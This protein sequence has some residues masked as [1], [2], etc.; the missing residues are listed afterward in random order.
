[1]IK[2]NKYYG[3]LEK[4]YLFSEIA[5]RVRR[6]SEANP[7]QEILRLGIGDVTLPLAPAV[8]AALHEA[9]D[10]LASAERFYGYGPE[11]GYPFLREVIAENDY[12][13]RGI[14]V[15]ADEIFISDG[16]KSDTGNFGDILAGD[17]TVAIADPVYPV[18]RDTNI[19]F[20]RKDSMIMLP[21]TAENGYTPSVPDQPCDL[22][23][24]CSPNNPTGAVM[25]RADLRDWVDYAL[26]NQSLI[27]FDAAYESF[28]SDADLV[29]SIF[30]IPGAEH[31][32]VEFRSFS[33]SAGFTGLRCAYTIIKKITLINDGNGKMVPLHDLW[34]RRQ[35]TRFN[36]ASYL[37]QRAAAAV[38]TPEG[39]KE[40]TAA[41]QYYKRN[42]EHIR[43]TL[44]N[45]GM[46]V[47]GGDNSPYVWARIPEGYTSWEYF[48]YLLKNFGIVVTPGSGFGSCGE[49]YVRFSAFGAWETCR[50]AMALISKSR[51]Q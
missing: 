29:K 25:S 40:A 28:I 18:Y 45:L 23:Y 32:A 1:M 50:K 42:A 11:Q 44:S 30:E 21:C 10:D 36:G 13:A 38:Y 17:L 27:L 47:T 37:S 6:H 15:S 39:K 35:T 4:S 19:M 9:V 49:G 8:I 20:G 24:L 46:A 22:I 7:E 26:A 5:A 12:R 51:D 3:D 14:D 16:A 31:C 34:L 41:I 43:S 48:D 33:K 2:A